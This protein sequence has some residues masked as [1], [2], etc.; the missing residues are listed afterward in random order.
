MLGSPLVA[1]VHSPEAGHP[2]PAAGIDHHDAAEA[3]PPV[4]VAAVR[5]SKIRVTNRNPSG[6][7]DTEITGFVDPSLFPVFGLPDSLPA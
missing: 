1:D 7:S 6:E 5:A 2:S 3:A 4:T